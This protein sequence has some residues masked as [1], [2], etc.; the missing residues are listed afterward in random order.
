MCLSP[1]RTIGIKQHSKPFI[2]TLTMLRKKL[3]IYDRAIKAITKLPKKEQAVEIH[4][5]WTSGSALFKFVGGTVEFIEG[6]NG[7]TLQSG[8]LTMIRNC[9]DGSYYQYVAIINEKFD[10][11]LTKEI[12]EDERIPKRSELITVEDLPVFA[13]WQRRIDTLITESK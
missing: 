8:C 6:T 13:E 3:D 2:Q 5:Q 4:K 12:K 9:E 10:K 1:L 11:A 7:E